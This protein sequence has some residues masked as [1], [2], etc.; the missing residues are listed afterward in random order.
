[1]NKKMFFFLLVGASISQIAYA[2]S[3]S[4]CSNLKPDF[5]SLVNSGYTHGAPVEAVAFMCDP[6]MGHRP[7]AAIGGHTSMCD[8]ANYPVSLRIATMNPDTG[9]LDIANSI[10]LHPTDHIYGLSWC[11]V[12][13]S[14]AAAEQNLLAVVGS[15]NIDD[16]NVWIYDV[17]GGVPANTTLVQTFKHGAGSLFSVDWLCQDC[18]VAGAAYPSRLLVIGGELGNG[19]DNVSLANIRILRLTFESGNYTLEQTDYNIF[20]IKVYQVAF[21]PCTINGCY[22]CAACAQPDSSAIPGNFQLYTVTCGG[23]FYAIMDPPMLVGDQTTKVRTVTWCCLDCNRALIAITID[24]ALQS[25]WNQFPANSNLLVFYYNYRNFS[26]MPIAYSDL[27]GI[28]LS[29]VWNPAP[30]CGCKHITVGG[31]CTE[32]STTNIYELSIDCSK[33]PN[34][35]N[36]LLQVASRHFDDNITSLAW[37]Y[38]PGSSNCSYL[39]VG[40]ECKSFNPYADL[41]PICLSDEDPCVRRDYAIFKALFCQK[42]SCIPVPV[43]ERLANTTA[44]LKRFK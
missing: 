33:A 38:K 25:D 6:D 41:D 23:S 22:Y 29:S 1:M 30:E 13:A 14:G 39:L 35:P 17:I 43:C 9:V 8:G 40:S 44:P 5:F 18:P 11:Y 15:Q 27:P 16:E 31:G 32:Y 36:K 24:P 26:L 3:C 21:S 34:Y 2:G 28:L 19:P 4:P 42:P 37:C 12:P 20:G 7:L 10:T